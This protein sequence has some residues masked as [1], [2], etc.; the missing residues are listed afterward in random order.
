MKPLPCGPSCNGTGPLMRYGSGPAGSPR[1]E[2]GRER[3]VGRTGEPPGGIMGRGEGR[4]F[5]I[6]ASRPAAPS[7]PAGACLLRPAGPPEDPGWRGE[8]GRP[9]W[10]GRPPIVAPGDLLPVGFRPPVLSEIA[11]IHCRSMGYPKTY[12]LSVG[13][14]SVLAANGRTSPN[15]KLWRDSIN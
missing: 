1:S 2:A 10:R 4:G 11:S 14:A 7:P 3:P 12:T 15:G 6:T 5:A 9:G 13:S 8:P